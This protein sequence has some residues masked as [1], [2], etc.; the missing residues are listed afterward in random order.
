MKSSETLQF[1]GV[2][3]SIAVRCSSLGG[4]LKARRSQRHEQISAA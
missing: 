3:I 4:D 1:F 2:M